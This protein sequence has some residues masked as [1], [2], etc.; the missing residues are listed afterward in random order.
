MTTVWIAAGA[1]L[2]VA[3]ALTCYRILAGPSSLDRLVAIDTCMAVAMCGL[4]VFAG[5]T[6][7]TTVV[8][9]IVAL[10]ATTTMP[11]RSAIHGGDLVF[12]QGHVIPGIYARSFMEGRITEEQLLNFRSEVGGGGLSS[13]PHPWLMPDYWQFPTVSMGL[14]PLMAIYQARFNRYLQNRGIKDTSQQNVWAFLGDGEMDEP[15][16]RGLLQARHRGG[17]LLHLR[18]RRRQRR[19]DRF[20]ASAQAGRQEV[21]GHRVEGDVVDGTGEAVAL[22]REH[23]VGDGDVLRLHC[24]DDLIAFAHV[25]AR[26]VGALADQQRFPDCVRL[27]QGR[28]RLQERLAVG[29]SGVAAH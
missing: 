14:G 16:S 21:L 22:V 19:A 25:D 23:D 5:A 17:A 20:C 9:A 29:R 2:L 1:M 18:R 7:D 28:A 11:A 6:H 8:P 4:A 27:G 13:Y 3:A 24:I 15:E 10:S 26:I 12:F